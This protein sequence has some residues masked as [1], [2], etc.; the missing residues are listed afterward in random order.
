MLRGDVRGEKHL[1]HSDQDQR[2]R[3]KSFCL[4]KSKDTRKNR[5]LDSPPHSKDEGETQKKRA[6]QKKKKEVRVKG[7]E[8]VLIASSGRIGVFV[9]GRSHAL[10]VNGLTHGGTMLQG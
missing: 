9:S 8:S 6:E 10:L 3:N 5:A 1:E 2:G 7:E 4:S